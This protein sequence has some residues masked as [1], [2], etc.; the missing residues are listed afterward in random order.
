MRDGIRTRGMTRHNFAKQ[1][2][3]F[4]Q[5]DGCGITASPGS[6]EDARKWPTCLLYGLELHRRKRE[7]QAAQQSTPAKGGAA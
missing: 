2:L 3:G 1:P 4:Y 5:C 6:D 7:A